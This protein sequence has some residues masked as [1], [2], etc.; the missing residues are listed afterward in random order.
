MDSKRQHKYSRLI[1]RDIAEIFQKDF[2]HSFGNAFITITDVQVT[3]D[4]SVARVYI[5]ILAAPDKQAVVDLI[6]EKKGAIRGELGRKIG[7]QVRIVPDLVF[8][9]DETEDRAE[10]MDALFDSLDIPPE[11]K[12]VDPE[13]PD[14]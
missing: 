3:P 7:K 8:F 14:S 6:Q 5:S 2:S 1:L 4:L 9:L 13:S 11:D 12:T 10:R